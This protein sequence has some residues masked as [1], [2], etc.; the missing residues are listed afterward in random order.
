ML[1]VA[2]HVAFPAHAGIAVAAMLRQLPSYIKLGA[3]SWH[4]QC[5]A[6]GHV[7]RFS[8]V[9]GALP[10]TH[11]R[12]SCW[13]TSDK[14]PA[15]VSMPHS[16]ASTSYHSYIAL[17][18]ASA[19]GL[20]LSATSALPACLLVRPTHPKLSACPTSGCTAVVRQPNIAM[21]RFLR[22]GIMQ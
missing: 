17:S 15:T 11:R 3:L 2:L 8:L 12:S 13:C 14:V 1:S 4:R 22:A 20:G 9:S 10:F 21:Q 7:A 5:Q 16:G 6:S 18:G 19:C